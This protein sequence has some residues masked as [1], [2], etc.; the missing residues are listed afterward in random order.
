MTYVGRWT[1]AEQESAAQ[2]RTA[3]VEGDVRLVRS[4]RDLRVRGDGGALLPSASSSTTMR[5]SRLKAC[6][7]GVTFTMS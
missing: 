5:G 2:H 3:L 4:L 7:S 1:G 6:I